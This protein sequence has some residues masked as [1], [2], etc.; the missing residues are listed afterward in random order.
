MGGLNGKTWTDVALCTPLVL[1]GSLFL[2]IY[3]RD[4]N[5]LTTGE[6]VAQSLGVNVPRSRREI[7]ILATAVTAAAVSVSGTLVFVG[8]LV[9]HILRLLVG[10][11]HRTL[12]IASFL[13]GASLLVLADLLARTIIAPDELRLGVLTSLMGGPFFLYLLIT[14]RMRVES[15]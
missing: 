5:V 15:I 9:P 1:G 4:L 8:L 11:E 12:M 10:P 2:L 3:A 7:L 6:E 13:G 14:Q